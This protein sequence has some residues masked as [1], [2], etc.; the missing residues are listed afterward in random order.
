MLHTK[1]KARIREVLTSSP[2]PGQIQ[3]HISS[4]FVATTTNNPEDRA[5]LEADLERESASLAEAISL[6]P[7]APNVPTPPIVLQETGDLKVSDMK[8]LEEGLGMGN[9]DAGGGER[10]KPEEN[11]IIT[12]TSSV[13]TMDVLWAAIKSLETA[14]LKLTKTH[15]EV[16]KKQTVEVEK[17]VIVHQDKLETQEQRLSK[18]ETIQ[19]NLVK[20][21]TLNMRK[22]EFMENNFRY[23]NIRILH[24]PFLRM[25]SPKDMFKEYLLH[26]LKIPEQAIPALVKIYYIPKKSIV[27][28]VQP[29]Q[30]IDLSDILETTLDTVITSRETLFVSFMFPQERDTILRLFLRNRLLNYHGQQIWMYP[31]LSRA[32]LSKLCVGTR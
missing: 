11:I 14:I 15:L 4:F 27:R 16:K 21:E 1:R 24:F 2:V 26:I 10:G 23:S 22:L 32:E 5:T 25:I 28:E 12:P 8:P 7:G 19:N 20:S 3:S 29:G 9:I 6:S 31:D 17:L 13:I 18:V 30:S